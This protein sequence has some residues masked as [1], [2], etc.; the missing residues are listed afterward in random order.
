MLLQRSVKLLRRSGIIT[1]RDTIICLSDDCQRVILN[2]FK[3]KNDELIY[4]LEPGLGRRID[5]YFV[6]Y[7]LDEGW[8]NF[9]AEHSAFN[10][11]SKRLFFTENL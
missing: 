1:L 5:S 8:R 3:Y 7:G 2:N 9:A 11:L 6:F 4:F 10:K